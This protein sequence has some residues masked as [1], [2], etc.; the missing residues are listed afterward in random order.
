MLTTEVL[1]LF[2]VILSALLVGLILLQV[3]GTGLGSTFGSSFSFYQTK[4][5]VEKLLFYLTIAIASL[6][7]VASALRLIL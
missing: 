7:L 5:G 4:R 2:Q 3:K 6:F 1:S